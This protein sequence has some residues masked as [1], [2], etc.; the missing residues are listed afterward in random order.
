MHEMSIIITLQSCN[1]YQKKIEILSSIK[2]S[3]VIIFKPVML[4]THKWAI[5]LTLILL[6]I[7][8]QIS[9]KNNFY[10]EQ[11]L[12]ISKF[13]KYLTPQPKHFTK[14]FMILQGIKLWITI[15]ETFNANRFWIRLHYHFNIKKYRC[16]LSHV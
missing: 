14:Q 4:Q 15:I 3:L 5:K 16:G 8:N 10:I 9:I 13:I 11:C 12:E 1:H 6:E 2:H 7:N